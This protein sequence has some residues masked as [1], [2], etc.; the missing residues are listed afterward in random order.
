MIEAEGS[1]AEATDEEEEP[2]LLKVV[3]VEGV[4]PDVKYVVARTTKQK[5][6][7]SEEM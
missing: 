6:A 2:H 1:E 7:I 3:W 5:T 4:I